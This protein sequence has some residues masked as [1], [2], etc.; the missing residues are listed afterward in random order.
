MTRP[1]DAIKTSL[2]CMCVGGRP[3]L[4]C[5]LLTV[6][7]TAVSNLCFFIFES[8]R[9]RI[10]FHSPKQLHWVEKKEKKKKSAATSVSI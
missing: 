4:S 3:V 7:E 6:G 2:L 8:Q 1:S 9:F 10:S 5:A